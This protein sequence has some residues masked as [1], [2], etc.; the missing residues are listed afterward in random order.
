[1]AIARRHAVD[2]SDADATLVLSETI[3][4]REVTAIRRACRAL[5][6]HVRTLHLD[7]AGV[8]Q[9]EGGVLDAVRGVVREWRRSREGNH[10]LEL[11]S[12]LLVARLEEHC[13]ASAGAGKLHAPLAPRLAL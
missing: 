6:A 3:S 9:F 13:P 2:I 7:L 12:P 8:T 1:M 5:P 10:R 11:V 4:R